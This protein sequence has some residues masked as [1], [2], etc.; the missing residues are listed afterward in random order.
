M[1]VLYVIICYNAIYLIGE[2]EWGSGLLTASFL[3]RLKEFFFYLLFLSLPKF[4]GL[5]TNYICFSSFLFCHWIIL[6]RPISMREWDFRIYGS[7]QKAYHVSKQSW[8]RLCWLMLWQKTERPASLVLKH[9]GKSSDCSSSFQFFILKSVKDKPCWSWHIHRSVLQPVCP[10]TP[11][12]E[13]V[14]LTLRKL[15]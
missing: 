4:C 12:P 9:L 13:I 2:G 8:H 6:F 10:V 7:E 3:Q 11:A 15:D 14:C 5:K 1:Y